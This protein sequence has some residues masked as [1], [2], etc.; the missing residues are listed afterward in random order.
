MEDDLA[1]AVRANRLITSFP[2]KYELIHLID[3]PDAPPAT[4]RREEHWR[5]EKRAVGRGGQGQV[6]LQTCIT[7]GRFHTQRAV[8]KI[9]IAQESGGR[10]RYMR[11]LRAITRF[12]RTNVR[13]NNPP[14]CGARTCLL[15]GAVL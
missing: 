12:S 7:G 3:D 15:I 6:F 13:K 5:T 9:P 1:R 11:E 2:R 10:K 8:K 14:L 4:P